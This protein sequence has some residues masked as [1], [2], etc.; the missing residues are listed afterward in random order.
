[1]ATAQPGPAVTA[2]SVNF[3]DENDAR[4]IFLALLEKVAHT[5][6][7]DAHKHLH[8][9]R[10]GDGEK[11]H[12]CLAGD[13]PCKQGLARSWRSDE[14]HAFGNAAPELLKLLR[15]LQKLDD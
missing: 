8:E 14:Q 11:R 2:Y 5:A 7:D 6:C 15:V 4:R 10:A 3:I 12:V 9:V 1:M 13:G